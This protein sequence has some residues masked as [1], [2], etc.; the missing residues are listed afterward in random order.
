MHKDASSLSYLSNGVFYTKP[1]TKNPPLLLV[2][3]VV[4]LN[5]VYVKDGKVNLKMKSSEVYL[6]LLEFLIV[7]MRQ[8]YDFHSKEMLKNNTEKADRLLK[9][10]YAKISKYYKNIP[11]STKSSKK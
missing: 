4:I 11:R 10:S 9:S 7:L 2:N 1:N 8:K 6:K 3:P 5:R